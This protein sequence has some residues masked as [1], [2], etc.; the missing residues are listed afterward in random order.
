GRRLGVPITTFP[1]SVIANGLGG[2]AVRLLYYSHEKRS[3]GCAARVKQSP[4]VAG[5]LICGRRSLRPE[6]H[7]TRDDN[8]TVSS[9]HNHNAASCHCPE[10]S[11]G[12]CRWK[13]A[14]PKG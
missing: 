9:A 7:R 12:L 6:D 13:P 11:R 14:A 1:E 2:N 3:T 10:H 4:S 8:G 5:A